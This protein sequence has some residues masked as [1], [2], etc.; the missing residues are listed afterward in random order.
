MT[1]APR[2][3][4][5]PQWLEARPGQTWIRSRAGD[6]L[7]VGW[8]LKIQH[9]HGECW[10]ATVIWPGIEIWAGDYINL[11]AATEALERVV[12]KLEEGV[13]K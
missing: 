3:H 10:R 8:L 5:A 1:E 13:P 4:H 2:T 7:L 11:K 9:P 12:T 6:G